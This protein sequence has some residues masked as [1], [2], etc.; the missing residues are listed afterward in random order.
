MKEKNEYARFFRM[1]GNTKPPERIVQIV[2][3]KIASVRKKLTPVQH[4]RI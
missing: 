1:D 2:A 4:E 3:D